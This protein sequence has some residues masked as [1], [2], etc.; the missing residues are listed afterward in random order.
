MHSILHSGIYPPLPTFFDQQEELD[1]A[2]LRRHIQALADSGIAGY[3][4]MGS[5]GEA[6]HLSSA[7]RAQV[8]ATTREAVEQSMPII[9]GCGEQST[10]ATIGLCQQA[11]RAGADVALIL[12]P[13]Y[14]RS[15][16]DAGTLVAHY[17]AIADSS[18]LPIVLYNMP[19]SAAGLDLDADSIC[20]LAQHPNIIGL[21]DSA[22]NI[23]KLAQVIADVP[24]DFRVF[25]GNAGFFLAA[26]AVGAVG[27][28]SALA[29]IF[30]HEVCLLQAL[31]EDGQLEEARSLQARII[32]ANAA[33]TTIY[34][35][36][37]LK[38]ALEYTAGYGGKPR[39]PLQPLSESE[40]EKLAAILKATPVES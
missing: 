18:P 36:P 31:F 10:R 19:S 12:P 14:Y 9:A 28:V 25:A 40:R 38:A 23:T 8:I 6:V 26:L 29:N 20:T 39:M 32:P 17:R 27:T 11:A 13:A 2:T 24:A 16:M 7:E 35:V 4:L 22:G 21:K 33:V 15:R 34:G 5:N 30:P 37:G 1:L 3:V